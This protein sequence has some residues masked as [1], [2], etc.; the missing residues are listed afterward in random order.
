M[1]GISI[2]RGMYR[3]RRDPE[4][5]ACALNAQRDLSAICDQ[6]FLKQV[7]ALFYDHQ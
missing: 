4:F 6:D 2:R 7:D 5:T 1:H 3:H